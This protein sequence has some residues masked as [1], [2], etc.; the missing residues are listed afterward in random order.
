VKRLRINLRILLLAIALC[1]VVFAWAGVKFG[2]RQTALT[3]RLE[4]L[5]LMRSY[6]LRMESQSATASER[7]GWRKSAAQCDKMISDCE[8]ELG[9]VG[10][11]TTFARD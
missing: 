1:A 4:D 10:L 9:R 11:S 8:R 2:Q 7:A 6:A 5:R 3:Y